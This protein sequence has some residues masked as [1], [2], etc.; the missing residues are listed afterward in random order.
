MARPT[1]VELKKGARVTGNAVSRGGVLL[2]DEAVVEGSILPYSGQI[3]LPRIDVVSLDPVSQGMPDVVPLPAFVTSPRLTGFNRSNGDVTVNGDLE[4]NDAMLY[5]DG[6]L[7]VSGGIEGHGVVVAKGSTSVDEGGS[8]T[9]TGAAALVSGG[10]VTL[11]GQGAEQSAFSGLIYSGGNF[12][13]SNITLVG[14]FVGGGTRSEVLLDSANLLHVPGYT[15]MEL[16]L[17]TTSTTYNYVQSDNPVW[18]GGPGVGADLVKINWVRYDG[19]NGEAVYALTDM[20]GQKPM[21]LPAFYDVV[22][23]YMEANGLKK[24]SMQSQYGSSWWN[25]KTLRHT[26]TGEWLPVS[27]FLKY[28]KSKGPVPKKPGEEKGPPIVKTKE[29]KYVFDLNRF[30]TNA[31]RISILLWRIE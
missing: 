25:V 19:D 21:P 11:H 16:N 15:R 29:G 17:T 10:D 9:G 23:Q 12:K 27:T 30:L 14:A 2:E 5:V 20:P 22:V 4:L 1:S 8:M 3:R 28:V 31:D 18:M 26:G 6:D 7:R 24:G 13:A